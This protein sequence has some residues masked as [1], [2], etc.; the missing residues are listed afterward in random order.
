M[1]TDA[2]GP[3]TKLSGG[4][5]PAPAVAQ[6]PVSI[7]QKEQANDVRGGRASADAPAFP[8]L[9]RLPTGAPST[10]TLGSQ[11]VAVQG[12]DACQPRRKAAKVLHNGDGYDERGS[13]ER[14]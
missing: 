7:E 5:P 1:E 10:F 6:G 13:S 2:Q 14:S 8:S 4:T 12:E 9:G 11:P 3:D